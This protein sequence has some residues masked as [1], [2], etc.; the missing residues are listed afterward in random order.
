VTVDPA[1]LYGQMCA[2]CHGPDGHGDAEMKKTLPKIRDFSDPQFR[3][4]DPD[5]IE[6]V[7]MAGKDQMPG[8][9]AA[10]SRVKIQHLSGYVRRLGAT[11]AGAT[12]K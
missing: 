6:Q 4:R 10:L 2:R 7:I 8:F 5:D 1:A 11:G 3:L 9:G 12:L